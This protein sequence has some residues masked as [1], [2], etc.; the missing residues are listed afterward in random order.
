[1][2]GFGDTGKKSKLVQG[3][4]IGILGQVVC[5]Q[6]ISLVICQIAERKLIAAATGFNLI[7]KPKNMV[8]MK[9]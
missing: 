4:D 1:M 8:T 9:H 2:I 5:F 7:Y 3:N 6:N